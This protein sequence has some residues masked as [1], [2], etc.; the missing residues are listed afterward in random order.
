MVLSL[1]SGWCF[2]LVP[3]CRFGGDLL[4]FGL[5]RA[6]ELLEQAVRINWP[7]ACKLGWAV[8]GWGEI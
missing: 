3:V 7:H 6:I 5:N 1:H 2:I 8:G 4:R